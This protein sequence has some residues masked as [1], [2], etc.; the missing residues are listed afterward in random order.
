ML[1]Q[2]KKKQFQEKRIEV[3]FLAPMFRKVIEHYNIPIFIPT[4]RTG[5]NLFHKELSLIKNKTFDSLLTNGKS[6]ALL[7][8]FNTRFNKYPKPIK[9]ALETTQKP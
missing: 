2:K 9:D 7:K 3:Y 1:N 5:I 8:F 6:Q 4:E